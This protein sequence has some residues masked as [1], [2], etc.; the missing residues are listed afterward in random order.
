MTAYNQI[1]RMN[2]IE[3]ARL[4][5]SPSLNIKIMPDYSLYMHLKFRCAKRQQFD[6]EKYLSTNREAKRLV[7]EGKLVD[8]LYHFMFNF[9]KGVKGCWRAENYSVCE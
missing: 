3:P 8:G 9:K 1:K 5:V 4:S 7:Q 2:I 6:N